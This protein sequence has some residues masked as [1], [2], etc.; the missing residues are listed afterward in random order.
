MV[1]EVNSLH[2][3]FIALILD[4]SLAWADNRR[5]RDLALGGLLIGLSMGNHVLTAFVAPYAIVYV[6]WAGRDTLM[7][8]GRWIL[9]PVATM[10]LGLAV[11]AYLPIA[12]SLDPPLPYNSP[13]TVA[14]FLFLV[15]GEQFRGQYS[16]LLTPDGVR[17]FVT[18]LP[19]LWSLAVKEGSALLPILGLGGV[20]VLGR[21]RPAFA[22]VLVAIIV[23]GVYV[24]ANYLRLEH[25]LLVPWLV[26]GIL[27]GVALD[28][29]ANAL[30]RALPA[31]LAA[32]PGAI[33]AAG[34]AVLAVALVVANLPAADRS[35][36]RTAEAWA[37]SL[38]ATLPEN[39]VIVTPWGASSPLWYATFV[40]GKRPDVLV[41]DDTNI[42]YEGWGTREKRIA[43]LICTRPVFTLRFGS[44][45]LDLMRR[46]YQLTGS[47]EFFVGGGNPWATV[48]RTLYRVEPPADCP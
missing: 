18:S 16:G 3:L 20:L 47:G 21:R 4:R 6:I 8:H 23:T 5:L 24:W 28:G 31:R 27:A 36:D 7:E 1:A 34:A 44:E 14:G 41:V 22:V 26:I 33:T 25:Y 15:T 32:A 42:V 37:D 48:Y 45:D 39:A 38:F 11:Y 17:M 40:D 12:A 2:L 43:S 10:A 13:V 29:L 19:D 9:A 30:V 46:D 35:G